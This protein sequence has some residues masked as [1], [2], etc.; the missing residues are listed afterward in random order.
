MEIFLSY[1][2]DDSDTVGRIYNELTKAGYKVFYDHNIPAGEDFRQRIIKQL[3][4]SKCV[5]TFWSNS[6]NKSRWVIDEAEYAQ[7]CGILIP[8]LLENISP[9]I[10]FGDLNAV[11]FT[12]W[13]G[14][15]NDSQFNKL[16]ES[17]DI[18]LNPKINSAQQIRNELNKILDPLPNR[19]LK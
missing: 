15:S 1:S 18:V 8:V 12:N 6:A 4:E 19:L 9:P 14:N 11:N 13:Y 7:S 2:R 5:I 17:I 16:K 3:K 10:G